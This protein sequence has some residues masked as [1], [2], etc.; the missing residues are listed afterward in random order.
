MTMQD[1]AYTS[2]Q[3]GALKGD[4]PRVRRLAALLVVLA[5]IFIPDL[6]TM[7]DDDPAKA[8]KVK[9]AYIYNFIKFVEWPAVKDPTKSRKASI[10]LQGGDGLVASL[11]SLKRQLAGT[12][13]LE[14][15]ADATKQ[16]LPGCNLLYIDSGIGYSGMVAAA[17]EHHVLTVSTQEGFADNGGI[18]EMRTV[19]K[20][21]GLFSSGKIN[22]RINIRAAEAAALRINPQ[23]QEIAVE[24]IK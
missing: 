9:A 14:I 8:N 24:I 15:V 12:L 23:L 22:L 3:R 18:M 7:A 6:Q 5:L 19:E 10:C 21:V 13:E 2:L 1:G 11:E 16:S 17:R 4:L 20:N